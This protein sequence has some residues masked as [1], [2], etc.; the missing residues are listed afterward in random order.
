M[1]KSFPE[2]ITTGVMTAALFCTS[3]VHETNVQNL[4]QL[5]ACFMVAYLI[6]L[7][8]SCV[9]EDAIEKYR[10]AQKAKRRESFKIITLKKS[11]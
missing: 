7:I 3:P 10:D 9:V 11:A 8:G 1:K 6:T 2:M 4:A 5:G